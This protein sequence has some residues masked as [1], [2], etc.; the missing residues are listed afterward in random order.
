MFMPDTAPSLLYFFEHMFLRDALFGSS[1]FLTELKRDPSNFSKGLISNFNRIKET[2]ND[3]LVE[4]DVDLKEGDFSSTIVDLAI[5]E[6]MA[7]INC[8]TPKKPPEAGFIGIVTGDYPRYFISE[9]ETNDKM[10]QLYPDKEWAPEYILCEWANKKH[11]NYGKVPSTRE[12]FIA[13]VS[14]ILSTP[15]AQ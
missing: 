3:R 8:P 11:I 9:Y 6:K 14:R 10:K 2:P 13:G 4:K 7:V 1:E 15:K 12:A 5:N